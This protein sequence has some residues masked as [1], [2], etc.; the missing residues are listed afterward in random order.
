MKESSEG[1]PLQRRVIALQQDR[2]AR[3]ADLELRF[4]RGEVDAKEA[5]KALRR[6]HVRGRRAEAAEE[7]F[8]AL[9]R[10]RG[11]RGWRLRRGLRVRCAQGQ[12]GEGDGN[13]DAEELHGECGRRGRGKGWP[14]G[15][16]TSFGTFQATVDG[17]QLQGTT[18]TLEARLRSHRVHYHQ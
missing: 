7:L 11:R 13:E 1:P 16:A 18:A 4:G 5:E 9:L 14:Q 6:Q 12:C 17:D 3:K 8:P 10:R 15:A 2:A